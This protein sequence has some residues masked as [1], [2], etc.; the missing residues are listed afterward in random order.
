MSSYDEAQGALSHVRLMRRVLDRLGELP[1]TVIQDFT[2]VQM[3]YME[4][5]REELAPD[6]LLLAEAILEL[7][8]KDDPEESQ[9]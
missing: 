1:R 7:E 3:T 9:A 2:L 6:A 5:V 4:V 8:E